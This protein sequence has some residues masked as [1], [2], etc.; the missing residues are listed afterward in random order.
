MALFETMRGAEH[1]ELPQYLITP[2]DQL[3][4]VRRLMGDDGLTEAQLLRMVSGA[5]DDAVGEGVLQAIRALGLAGTGQYAPTFGM[6]H[7]NL[8]PQVETLRGAMAAPA[9]QPE[10]PA[11]PATPTVPG[12]PPL[13]QGYWE[14]NTFM[15]PTDPPREGMEYPNRAPT[16]W[17]LPRMPEALMQPALPDYYGGNPRL[18]Q[19]MQAVRPRLMGGL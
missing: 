18:L 13:G 10:A 5:P 6:E 9:P 19:Q 1:A 16:A 2:Q 8:G 15:P 4:N 12:A 17:P 11:A 7:A 14:G 3:A